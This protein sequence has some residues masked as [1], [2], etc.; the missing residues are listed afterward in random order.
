M[1]QDANLLDIDSIVRQIPEVSHKNNGLLDF[2]VENECYAHI[3]LN[4][5]NSTVDVNLVASLEAF[6]CSYLLVLWI[7][8]E[9]AELDNIESKLM[10][11]KLWASKSIVCT[12][13]RI[14]AASRL[15]YSQVYKEDENN[16][17]TEYHP[18]SDLQYRALEKFKRYV[19]TNV[20]LH[21]SRIRASDLKKM[22]GLSSKL[23]HDELIEYLNDSSRKPLV[24]T[25][26]NWAID[27][28][29]IVV[30]CVE[31][32]SQVTSANIDQLVKIATFLEQD[33]NL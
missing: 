29:L 24:S 21:F 33:L 25:R 13:Q 12:V 17:G 6:Y 9:K 32:A 1:Q 18:W 2:F 16:N 11:S 23:S 7:C 20:A 4:K 15:D 28:D 30:P 26:E 19:Y 3:A 14:N 31:P 22:L 10:N 5:W 27:G 8:D